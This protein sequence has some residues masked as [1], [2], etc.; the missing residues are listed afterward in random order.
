M[1]RLEETFRRSLRASQ[2]AHDTALEALE[3]EH[4]QSLATLAAERDNLVAAQTVAW[5]GARRTLELQL[6]ALE[7]E[8]VKLS[9]AL[10]RTSDRAS[11][12]EAEL[13][14]RSAEL[15]Q[16]H[17]ELGELRRALGLLAERAEGAAAPPED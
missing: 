1:S 10:E 9:G 17:K 15:R 8:R 5:D 12:L 2:G 3:K 4:A 7:T 11:Q 6:E 14:R 16:T 13:A